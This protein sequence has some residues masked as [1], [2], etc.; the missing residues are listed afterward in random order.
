MGNGQEAMRAL[1]PDPCTL[2]PAPYCPLPLAHRRP[3][4][5]EPQNCQI[6]MRKTILFAVVQVVFFQKSV[7]AGSFL[8]PPCTCDSIR[9]DS[10]QTFDYYDFVQNFDSSRVILRF[11]ELYLHRQD[12]R[13]LTTRLAHHDY[14]ANRPLPA[15]SPAELARLSGGN[16]FPYSSGDT[17]SYYWTLLEMREYDMQSDWIDIPDTLVYYLDLVDAVSGNVI[18][19]FDSLGVLPHTSR[20]EILTHLISSLDTGLVKRRVFRLRARPK[21]CGSGSGQFSRATGRDSVSRGGIF[22][23]KV[24]YRIGFALRIGRS[25]PFWTGS[26]TPSRPCRIVRFDQPISIVL[27]TPLR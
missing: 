25:I 2:N 21:S 20:N 5:L 7:E 6:T 16:P 17:V 8:E 22:S 12:G 14:A 3:M 10:I 4:H 23:K 13:V 26:S 11:G 27:V 24:K 19:T 1:N 9:I 18:L 15:S